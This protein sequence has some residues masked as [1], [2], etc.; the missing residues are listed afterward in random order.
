MQTPPTSRLPP[1]PLAH[2]AMPYSP[3]LRGRIV[4]LHKMGLSRHKTGSLVGKFPSCASR[5]LRHARDRPAA[6]KATSRG[7]PRRLSDRQ[8]RIVKRLILS[9]KCNTA[10]EIA[11]QASS[12]KLPKA[13]SRTF[14]RVLRRQGLVSRVKPEKPAVTMLHMSRR[15]AWARHYRNW[16]VSDWEKDIFSDETK[17]LRVNARGRSWYWSL[18]GDRSLGAGTVKASK[19]FGGGSLLMWGCMSVR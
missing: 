10:A 15:L 16:T 1:A 7:P 8:E 2:I 11:R 6:S 12:L 9:G 17:L 5:F 19:K 13:S 14:Q 18:R 4:A 3:S